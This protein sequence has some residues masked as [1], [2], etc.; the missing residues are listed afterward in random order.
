MLI[1]LHEKASGMQ[2]VS[3]QISDDAGYFQIE[4]T[5]KKMASFLAQANQDLY[6]VQRDVDNPE[7]AVRK[8]YNLSN[9][10]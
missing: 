4:E 10:I 9:L 2:L 7:I 3:R 5:A 8:F 1:T 6:A